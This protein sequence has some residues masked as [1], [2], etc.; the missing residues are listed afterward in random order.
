MYVY[1]YIYRIRI[2]YYIF[3]FCWQID[4]VT[5]SKFQPPCHGTPSMPWPLHP[6]QWHLPGH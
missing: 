2:Y 1:I 6:P 3:S 4:T 5:M